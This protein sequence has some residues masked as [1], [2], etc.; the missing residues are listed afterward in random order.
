MGQEHVRRGNWSGNWGGR[1]QKW[2]WE[3]AA[4]RETM[5][6][7]EEEINENT[8]RWVPK[9]EGEG[10]GKKENSDVNRKRRMGGLLLRD[11]PLIIHGALS[12]PIEGENRSCEPWKQPTR[13]SSLL[14][15]PLFPPSFPQLLLNMVSFVCCVFVAQVVIELFFCFECDSKSL[16][17]GPYTLR[18]NSNLAGSLHSTLSEMALIKSQ[19]QS[20]TECTISI[21]WHVVW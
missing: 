17:Y 20:V 19:F 12:T 15:L 13:S 1:R 21:S 16:S 11:R 2:T 9:K 8:H 5:S 7:I 14:S 4:E 18:D 10:K 6:R 3:E